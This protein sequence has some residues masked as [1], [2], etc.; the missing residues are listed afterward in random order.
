MGVKTDCG[1]DRREEVREGTTWSCH[2]ESG[3][4]VISKTLSKLL[5]NDQSDVM[6]S[7]LGCAL[8]SPIS[9]IKNSRI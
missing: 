7:Y 1:G 4:V 6:L 8:F 5:Y 2:L 9:K 3:I